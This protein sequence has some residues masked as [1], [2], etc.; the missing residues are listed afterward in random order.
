MSANNQLIVRKEKEIFVLYHNMCVDNDFKFEKRCIIAKS[1]RIEEI[2][3]IAQKF[4]KENIVEY[5]ISLQ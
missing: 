1:D 2:L 4:M 5:G 3:K